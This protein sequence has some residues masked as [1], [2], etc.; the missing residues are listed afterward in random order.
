M[1]PGPSNQSSG[2]AATIVRSQPNALRDGPQRVHNTPSPNLELDLLKDFLLAQRQM[3][4]R[5]EGEI[6]RILEAVQ[7]QRGKQ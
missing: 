1:E 5:M 4:R 2:G 3:H 6:G 7:L